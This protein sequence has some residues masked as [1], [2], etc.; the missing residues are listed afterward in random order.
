MSAQS[1]LASAV[2]ELAA[3]LPSV[4]IRANEPA[5]GDALG[6]GKYQR[7]IVVNWL[8]GMPRHRTPIRMVVLGVR[9][10]GV[11]P[12]DAEALGMAVEA[13]FHDKGARQ[14]AGAGVWF[15]LVTASGPDTDP[16]TRQPLWHSTVDYPITYS[17]TAT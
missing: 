2:A 12:P 17:E 11:T 10:Y 13:V 5:P 16:D 1:P 15:S 7:F 6:P 14:T 8:A 4:L 3:A 9:S